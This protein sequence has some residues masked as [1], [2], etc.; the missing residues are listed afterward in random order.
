M[1]G[2]PEEVIARSER[3]LDGSGCEGALD[4]HRR[5]L[6]LK[7]AEDQAHHGRRLLGLARRE[8]L[9][10][11]AGLED[12]EQ[13]LTFVGLAVLRDPPRP[14]ARQAVSDA[15]GAGVH[16]LMAT[17]DHPATALAIAREVGLTEDGEGAVTRSELLAADLDPLAAPVYA[18]LNPQD[19]LD[20]VRNLQRRG[21][22]VAV[23]GDGVNDVP[24]LHQADVGVAMGRRG[25]QAAHETADIVVT[26]DNLATIVHAIRA[27]RG[28]LDNI[29]KVV[30]YLVAANLA[31]VLVVVG[32][33]LLFPDLGVPL[34]PLQLLWINLVTDGLP[35]IALGIDAPAPGLM[36][37]PPRPREEPLLDRRVFVGLGGRAVVLA[38]ACLAVLA[39][40]RGLWDEPW[41]QARGLMF[42]VL[43]MSQLLY[44]LALR[45]RS[46]R[47]HGGQ[48]E[49]D[50][51]R[52]AGTLLANP[53]LLAGVGGGLLLQVG[54]SLWLPARSLL[55]AAQPSTSGWMLV[56]AA[57]F[58]PAL[59]IGW[60]V[61][62]PERLKRPPTGRP[63]Q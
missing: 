53:W 2:A 22:I 36:E 5:R 29:R 4:D 49:R 10:Q 54:V 13:S 58:A 9:E 20:L 44:A 30:E 41:P 26:D 35:A 1:K 50:A 57:S 60:M 32:A 16:V 25:T 40:S 37:Q 63:V 34:L 18:R 24:A 38:G 11:P 14:Q 43:A 52:P 8:L 3:L 39:V 62:R 55:D 12:A 15:R 6:L 56:A 42:S 21:H 23:T 7:A 33:L 48:G 59:A 61:T 31:E 17:G 47:D 46:R 28:I 19:K 51:K 27:G 45:T